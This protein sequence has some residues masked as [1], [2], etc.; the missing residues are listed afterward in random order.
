MAGR[1][2]EARAAVVQRDAGARHHHAGAEAAV[3]R[4]DVRHHAALGVGRAQVDGAA[5]WRCA[6]GVAPGA[7][8][9]DQARAFAQVGGLEQ[10]RRRE[11]H[12][13]RVTHVRLQVGEG[14][15][16]GFDLEVHARGGTD[17]RV[18]VGQVFE[19]AQRHQRRDA[20]PVR[21]NLVHLM[22][23]ETDAD[24]LDPFAAVRR[25]VRQAQG[26]AMRRREGADLVRQPAGV[27]GFTPRACDLFERVGLLRETPDLGHGGCAAT[28]HEGLETGVRLQ[29]ADGLG[30]LPGD[31]RAHGEAVARMADRIDEQVLEGQ[32]AETLRQRRPARHLTRHGDRVPTP[33]R[34]GVHALEARGVP[35]RGRAARGVEAVQPAALPHQREAVAADAV[36][37]RLDHRQRDGRRQRGV[38]GVAATGEGRR[39]SL[40]G[41]GLRGRDDVARQHGLPAGGIGK[42][43]VHESMCEGRKNWMATAWSCRTA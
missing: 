27:E 28:R 39:A 32:R 12:V 16:H 22:A 43:P 5:H 31:D 40:C 11:L 30:P 35:A 33:R 2:D 29:V 4:L 9:V 21:R 23:A 17:G 38:D 24:R 42:R 6:G 36:H 8:R 13:R 19:H 14:Q 37:D 20:L 3:V 10:L 25:Q 7:L 34:H 18:F 1:G 15:A 26:R 41:Q